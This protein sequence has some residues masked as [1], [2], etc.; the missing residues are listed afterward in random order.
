MTHTF[1]FIDANN[2]LFSWCVVIL[3]VPCSDLKP[4]NHCYSY[5]TYPKRVTKTQQ[6]HQ[7]NCEWQNVVFWLQHWWLICL[8]ALC[9]TWSNTW[10]PL[11]NCWPD[12]SH[13]NIQSDHKAMGVIG[14]SIPRLGN[15]D[16]FKV[17]FNLVQSFWLIFAT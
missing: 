2:N 16:I 15:S 11:S 12:A 6:L 10:I 13:P 17:F 14:R 3:F 8:Y 4:N 1:G 5:F 7:T 9:R